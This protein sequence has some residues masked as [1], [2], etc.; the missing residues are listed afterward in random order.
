MKLEEFQIGMRVCTTVSMAS[1]ETH[2]LA[3][4]QGTI[5]SIRVNQRCYP[6]QVNLD[7]FPEGREIGCNPIPFD[8]WELK[9]CNEK[10]WH[11][12]K[13]GNNE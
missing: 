5:E 10:C 1:E 6:I 4:R 7:G 13:E 2:H 9:P 3:A 8:P 11:Y 12:K